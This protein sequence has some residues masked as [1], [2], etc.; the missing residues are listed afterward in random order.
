MSLDGFSAGPD[1]SLDH[2]LGVGGPALMEWFF[3]TRTWRRMHG[4]AD[5]AGA[6]AGTP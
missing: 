1:Q 6:T 5:G 3:A 4:L 2:P